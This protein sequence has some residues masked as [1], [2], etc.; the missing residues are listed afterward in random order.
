VVQSSCPFT[1]TG[2]DSEYIGDPVVQIAYNGG[3]NDGCMGLSS[4]SSHYQTELL[5]CNVT[6][7]PG[8]GGGFGT[9]WVDPG[10]GYLVS[11]GAT[12]ASEGQLEAD[13]QLVGDGFEQP[14]TVGIDQGK[15]DGTAEIWSGLSG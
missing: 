4:A 14:A 15:C 6:G 3:G 9:I 7:S 8:T 13:C 11:V 2:I 10:G 12:N 5:R 1:D